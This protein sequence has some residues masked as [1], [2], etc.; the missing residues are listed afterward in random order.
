MKKLALL[1]VLSLLVSNFSTASSSGTNDNATANVSVN[2]SMHSI[3]I[4]PSGQIDESENSENHI[5]QIIASV[6]EK[7]SYDVVFFIHGGLNTQT[8]NRKRMESLIP[9]MLADKKYPIF[10]NWKSGPY[11]NYSYHLLTVR[12]GETSRILGPLTF[13]FILLE[14]ATRSITRSPVSIYNLFNRALINSKLFGFEEERYGFHAL[15]NLKLDKE[16]NLH[17]S[18]DIVNRDLSNIDTL[19]IFNPLKIAIAPFADGLGKGAWSSMLRQTDLVLR[20]RC[21]YEADGFE[22][23][24]PVLEEADDGKTAVSQLFEIWKK[25]NNLK[26]RNVFLIGHSMGTI[27]ANNILNKNPEIKFNSIVYMASAARIKDVGN[28]VSNYLKRTENT[29]TQFYNLAL[30][31]YNDVL[32]NHYF[33]IIP[34]GSL[35]I[36]LDQFLADV[37]SFEDRTAGYAFNILRAAKNAFPQEIRSNVHLTMFGMD[38]IGIEGPQTHGDFD[39]YAFWHRGFWT[40]K[41]GCMVKAD[42]MTKLAIEIKGECK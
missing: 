6:K 1:G 37:D 41:S 16:F 22:K 42:Q 38:K 18:T 28:A 32:E 40:A 7:K 34:N 17:G 11:I 5:K 4:R 31:P 24:P 30:N 8:N 33:G 27:I 19:Y 26:D 15:H 36:W 3:T 13:P 29:Q 20:A 10:I 21:S 14:D 23:C 39:G 9:L 12:K 35:L 25:D 2:L